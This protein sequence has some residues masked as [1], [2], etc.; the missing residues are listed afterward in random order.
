MKLKEKPI[1]RNFLFRYQLEG[2][3]KVNFYHS[4]NAFNYFQAEKRLFSYFYRNDIFPK[5]QE[6]V[7]VMNGCL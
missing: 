6:L 4:I 3:R 1:I 2:K 7:S 5:K